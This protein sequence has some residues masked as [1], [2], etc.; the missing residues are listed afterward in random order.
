MGEHSAKI[1]LMQPGFQPTPLI[2]LTAAE[3]RVFRVRESSRKCKFYCEDN[4][5]DKIIKNSDTGR[6]R[7]FIA[8]KRCAAGK[9]D[10]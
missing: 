7:C 2:E 8:Q 1:E 3:Y 10:E 5:K 9:K 4:L 6:K